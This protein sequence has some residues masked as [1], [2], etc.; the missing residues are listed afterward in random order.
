MYLVHCLAATLCAVV[1]PGVAAGRHGT[2]V[3]LA[4]VATMIDMAVEVIR[5]VVPGAG[6]DEEAISSEPLGPIIAIRSAVVRRTF[7]VPV[8]AIRRISNAN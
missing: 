7:V 5:P 1:S 6:A 8:G 3:T 4:I 2:V